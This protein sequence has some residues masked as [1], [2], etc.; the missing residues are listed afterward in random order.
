MKTRCGIAPSGAI[1]LDGIRKNLVAALAN[2]DA[3]AVRI[4]VSSPRS[5]SLRRAVTAMAPKCPFPPVDRGSGRGAKD[6]PENHLCRNPVMAPRGR[7]QKSARSN[8]LYV[9]E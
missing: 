3:G 1:G 6:E 8:K 5:G 7:I 4:G 9:A 2:H